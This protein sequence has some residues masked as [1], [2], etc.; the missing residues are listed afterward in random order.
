MVLLKMK[1][2]AEAYLGSPVSNA[3]I[4]VPAYFNHS[5]RQATK[6]AGVISGL[7]VL[8]IVDE[9]T[10]AGLSLIRLNKVLCERNVLI[11][12]L[13]GGTLGVSLLT[14]EDTIYEVKAVAGDNHLGGEDFDNRLVDHFVR[15]FK[16]KHKKG[17]LLL[18]TTRSE[19]RID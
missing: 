2:T 7:T 3:V 8:R 15:E 10:A 6:N 19:R 1:R 14:I 5:Q 18:F 13:G 9:S 11:F 4:S 17:V 12:D 16:R